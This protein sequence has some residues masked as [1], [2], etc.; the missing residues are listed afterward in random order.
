MGYVE[1][2]EIEEDV[3]SSAMRLFVFSFDFVV[4]DY[5]LTTSFPV[6]IQG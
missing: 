2:K 5:A 4:V 1:G 6:L 3:Q